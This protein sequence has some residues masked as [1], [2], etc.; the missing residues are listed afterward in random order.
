MGDENSK[1]TTND[2]LRWFN[3]D[4][5]VRPEDFSQ[6]LHQMRTAGEAFK[7][8]GKALGELAEKFNSLL[9]DINDALGPEA[10][11]AMEQ[12]AAEDETPLP[13]YQCCQ[14]ETTHLG[15]YCGQCHHTAAPGTGCKCLRVP[16]PFDFAEGAR[17]KI[18]SALVSVIGQ[19]LVCYQCGLRQLVTKQGCESCSGHIWVVDEK[20]RKKTNGISTN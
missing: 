20:E 1:L 19:N 11:Q 7:A 14:C 3:L 15:I 5:K 13:W 18:G 6:A 2:V 8:M 4:G 10:L 12:E 9:A 16:P 17:V